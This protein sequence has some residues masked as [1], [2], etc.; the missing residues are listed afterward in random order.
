MPYF[1]N[2]VDGVK[3]SEDYKPFRFCDR[4]TASVAL[5]LLNSST[6]FVY[7]VL[8]GDCFHCGKE[9]VESFPAG[10]K[11]M[12]LPVSQQLRSLGSALMKDM[13]SHAVRKVAMSRVTGRMEYD[14]FWPRHS[15][16]IIDAIDTALATHYGFTQE[17]LDYVI[18]YDIKYRLGADADE[19]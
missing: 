7:F 17:E 1:C 19:K 8:Y 2:E 14:E 11:E 18:N 9:F 12:P 5:A 13:R 6:F 16:S 3:K 10:F 15:K 4:E